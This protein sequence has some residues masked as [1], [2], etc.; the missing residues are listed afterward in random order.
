[1]VQILYTDISSIDQETYQ[2][3]YAAASCSRRERADRYRNFSD[4]VRCLVGEV[5]LR[6]AL[7]ETFGQWEG[8]SLA[9]AEHGKPYVVGQPDFHFSIS[10]S[11]KWVVLAYG[12]TELGVDIQ[13]LDSKKNAEAVARRF[14]TEE[15]QQY[16]TSQADKSLAF[17][18]IWTG[19][20]SYLKYLGTGLAKSL[21]SFS[22]LSPEEG[23]HYF[24]ETLDGCSLC[25]CTQEE[26]Y[27]LTIFDINSRKFI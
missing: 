3:L 19:K 17:S 13:D 27:K 21:T 18:K 2:Q 7:A 16:L 1:M 5:L 10:H 9:Q 25:L 23:I 8:F 12:C 14:F 6:K 24:W 26:S 4:A 11:D 22:V 15:E 20:E